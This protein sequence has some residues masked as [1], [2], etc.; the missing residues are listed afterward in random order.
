MRA[1]FT[2]LLRKSKSLNKP[3]GKFSILQ[4]LLKQLLISFMEK[5][6]QSTLISLYLSSEEVIVSGKKSERGN[7][8]S[9]EVLQ[10]KCS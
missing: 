8:Q 9:G 1:G 5:V 10:A 7:D 4:I 6:M 3:K 2:Q